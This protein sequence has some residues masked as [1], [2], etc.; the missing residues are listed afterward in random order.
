MTNCFLSPYNQIKQL[1][2]STINNSVGHDCIES[3]AVCRNHPSHHF[4]FSKCK[5]RPNQ[6]IFTENCNALNMDS[7]DKLPIQFFFLQ[8]IIRR[9]GDKKAWGSYSLGAFK[10]EM[11]ICS[12]TWLQKKQ[13]S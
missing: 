11:G 2:C 6:L 5:G 10:N 7:Q 9:T 3:C 1:L 8:F 12:P 13:N 4:G